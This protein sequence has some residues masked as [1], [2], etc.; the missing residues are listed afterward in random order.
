MMWSCPFPDSTH[1]PP[2][3]K[4][5]E[6][7][8][9]LRRH[10]VV[11]HRCDLRSEVDAT[12][13]RVNFV[14]MLVGD[15]YERALRAVRRG[16]RRWRSGS[17]PSSSS[18]SATAPA[19]A[20][21]RGQKRGC[22]ASTPSSSSSSSSAVAAAA[23]SVPPSAALASE[24]VASSSAAL[25]LPDLSA[26]EDLDVD[27][28]DL[29]FPDELLEL[30][31]PVSS[32]GWE[33]PFEE[34][35]VPFCEEAALGGD[36]GSRH[37]ASPAGDGGTTASGTEPGP[38][39]EGICPARMFSAAETIADVV[40]LG[41]E[42]NPNQLARRVAHRLRLSSA[43]DRRAVD[44][45]VSAVVAFEGR[46]T[47]L[48]A[49][50]TARDVVSPPDSGLPSSVQEFALRGRRPPTF[51]PTREWDEPASTLASASPVIV[52]D[53]SVGSEDRMSDV[54]P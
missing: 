28:A 16:Q 21:R 7:R 10:L 20:V 41:P 9:G 33:S 35:L 47:D 23:S 29:N 18:S 51:S 45:A 22:P 39:E 42:H 26:G 19:A 27:W 24:S 3:P 46:Y 38:D 50:M 31:R 34:F 5:V 48:L 13:T 17:T 40:L 14:V 6:A 36:T 37:G 32:L 15:A 4:V 25:V 52:S 8:R 2:G 12:G 11:H 43:A 1:S 44:L 53:D 54:E 49:G 30:S